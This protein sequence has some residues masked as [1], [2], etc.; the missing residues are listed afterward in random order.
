M[1]PSAGRPFVK[2]LADL[3]TA[4]DELGACGLDVGDGQVQVL[5]GAGRGR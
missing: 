3:D 2:H 4:G 1:E 5:D